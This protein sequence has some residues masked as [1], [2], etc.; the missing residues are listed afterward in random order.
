M[1]QSLG[2]K[3][4]I[5]DTKHH[6]TKGGEARHKDPQRSPPPPTPARKTWPFAPPDKRSRM[7][8]ATSEERPRL[9][10][11]VGKM[12]PRSPNNQRRA[13]RP[14]N[15]V[16]TEGRSSPRAN[17]CTVALRLKFQR[18]TQ[19]EATNHASPSLLS[20]KLRPVSEEEEEHP[21]PSPQ[22]SVREGQGPQTRSAAGNIGIRENTKHGT[23]HGERTGDV[24]VW[25]HEKS[26][27]DPS[28]PFWLFFRNHR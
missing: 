18:E 28:D 9:H 15:P 13:P 10:K 8:C 14:P 11:G 17:C 26:D 1:A 25:Q 27:P 22:F 12:Q 21:K 16:Q 6:H 23:G 20:R 24:A 5:R 19:G 7:R 3:Q 4:R 2:R